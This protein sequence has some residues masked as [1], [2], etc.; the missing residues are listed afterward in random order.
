MKKDIRWQQRFSNYRK[1][2][3]QLSQNIGY[4]KASYENLDFEDEEV[5][6]EVTKSIA[7]I[8]K[9]GLIQSFEFTHELAWKVMQDFAEDQGNAEIRGSKDA[10]RYAA[11]VNL[12]TNAQ[13]WMNMILSRNETSHTYNAETADEIFKIVIKVYYPLFVNFE[14]KIEHIINGNQGKLL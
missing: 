10:T 6:E 4:I 11:Q 13:E 1:A 14:N 7:D 5:F 8:L 9:Q 3:N 12:I 2:L